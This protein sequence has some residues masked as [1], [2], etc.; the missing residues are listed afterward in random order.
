MSKWELWIESQQRTVEADGVCAA[1]IKLEAP[2]GSVWGTW[3]AKTPELADMIAQ[4]IDLLVEDLPKERH[5]CRLVSYDSKGEQLAVMPHSVQGR[6]AEAGK[7]ANRDRSHAQA[8]AVH[9]G[10]AEQVLGIQS[11]QLERQNTLATELFD[12]NLVLREK[13]VGL[14]TDTLALRTNERLAEERLAVFRDLVATSKPMLES[15]ISMG[16]E[17]AQYKFSEWVKQLQ[18]KELAAES[19]S[20]ENERLKSQLAES[21]RA[22]AELAE[23]KRL[24]AELSAELAAERERTNHAE[25]RKPTNGAVSD[26]AQRT[27]KTPRDGAGRRPGDRGRS[28]GNGRRPSATGARRL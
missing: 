8:T 23:S 2:D 4:A 16:A 7:I 6:S 27:R 28:A 1:T 9:L 18:Q 26:G 21:Q 24:A 5:S 19:L 10:N 17:L 22:A 15:V 13:L 14:M 3:P 25:K 12:D 20:T 11:R